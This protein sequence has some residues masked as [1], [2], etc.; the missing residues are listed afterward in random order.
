MKGKTTLI[1]ILWLFFFSIASQQTNAQSPPPSD[2]T[3]AVATIAGDQPVQLW[4]SGDRIYI[5]LGKL[6]EATVI[7]EVYDLTGRLI[8]EVKLTG[9]S[10]YQQ[11]TTQLPTGYVIAKLTY[12]NTSFTKKLLVETK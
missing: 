10:V 3:T 7:L 6:S 4:S 1:T 12:N 5:D 9:G 8:T 11:P 2:L